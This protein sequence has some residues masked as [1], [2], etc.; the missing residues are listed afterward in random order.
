MLCAFLEEIVVKAVIPP[1]FDSTAFF[2]TSKGLI[3]YVPQNA[4]NDYKVAEGWKEYENII[5]PIP[6][7]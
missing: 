6:Q 7:N 2:A 5:Y 1:V 4:V 3:I